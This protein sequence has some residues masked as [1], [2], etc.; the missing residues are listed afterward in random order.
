MSLSSGLLPSIFLKFQ[1]FHPGITQSSDV[2]VPC[3]SGSSF[4]SSYQAVSLPHQA[5]MLSNKSQAAMGYGLSGALGVALAHPD[6][7]VFL[8]EGDGGFLQNLQELVVA[9]KHV[10]NLRIFLWVNRGYASIRQTQRNYFQGAWLGCDEDSGLAFPDW[11]NLFASF[12]IE[13]AIMTSA[14]F[15]DPD[16][17]EFLKKDQ[18]CAVLVPIHPEQTFFPKISSRVTSAGSMESNPLH[19]IGPDLPEDTFRRVAP[20]FSTQTLTE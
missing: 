1:L 4:T 5:L 11:Q 14:G 19:L 13:C 6:R 16:L 2:L 3:S 10:S 8:V 7:P 15:A 12:G 18:A 9:Y 17:L 20:Y